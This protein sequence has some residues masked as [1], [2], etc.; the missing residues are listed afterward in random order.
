MTNDFFTLSTAWVKR[1]PPSQPALKG[2][3]HQSHTYRSYDVRYQAANIASGARVGKAIQDKSETLGYFDAEIRVP[4]TAHHIVV[5]GDAVSAVR[6]VI[7]KNTKHAA[8]I[9]VYSMTAGIPIK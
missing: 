1:G 7:A 6:S 4:T 3:V 5:A 2:R 9:K 8:H